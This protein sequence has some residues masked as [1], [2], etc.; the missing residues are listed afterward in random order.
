M[1]AL[2]PLPVRAELRRRAAT[3]TPA[4]VGNLAV[5]LAETVARCDRG[6]WT[7]AEA[8]EEAAWYIRHFGLTYDDTPEDRP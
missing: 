5:L 3:L 6:E 4:D 1:P 8:W 2:A 7:D